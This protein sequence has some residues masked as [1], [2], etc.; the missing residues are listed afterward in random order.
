[1]NTVKIIKLKEVSSTNEYLRQ[2]RSLNPDEITVVTAEFQTAGKGQGKN[3]WES[4]HGENL[5][6]SLLCHRNM[7]RRN[8]SSSSRKP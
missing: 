6:F 4:N 5:L 1:M 2:Y 3:T 7:C 8:G